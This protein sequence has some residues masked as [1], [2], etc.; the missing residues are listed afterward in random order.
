MREKLTCASFFAGVGGIDLGFES[1]GFFK[2]VYANEFDP[3]PVETLKNNFSDIIID[4]RDIKEVQ[5]SDFPDVDVIM[6]GFPCQAFSVAGYRKGFEDEKGRGT[7]F[8]ELLRLIKAKKPQIVFLENV[9]NLQSHDKGNTY[10]V[11]KEALEDAGYHVTEKVLNAMKHG[12]VPQNRERIY[13]VG[14]LSME[15]KEH[16]D[17]PEPIELTNTIKDIIDFENTV[18]EKYYYT[19]GKYKGDIYDQLKAEMNDP[20]TVYQW[21][22]KYVRKNQSNVVPTLTANMGEGGH[23]VPLVLTPSGIRKLTPKECFNAQGFPMGFDLPKHLNDSKLYKQAGN[24]VCVSVIE[25]IAGNIF[26]A[27]EKME[28]CKKCNSKIVYRGEEVKYCP[29]CGEEFIR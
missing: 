14:F 24:S 8:F 11:I 4:C 9:K 21:R 29:Y 27:I 26:S 19:E 15:A 18:D 22:R 2:T 25:R 12:N 20:S 1:T 7:L 23:N 17:F 3:Y 28:I 16:F 5:P 13:I 6:G 10:R